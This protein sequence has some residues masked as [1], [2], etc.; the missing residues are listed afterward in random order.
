VAF[1][2]ALLARGAAAQGDAGPPSVTAQAPAAALEAPVLQA[3][4]EAVYPAQA[5]VERREANVGL[6]L[7]LDETGKV[8]SARVTSPAGHGFDEAALA[9]ARQ[10]RFQPA[11]LAGVP[12]RSSVQFTYEFQLPAP[13]ASPGETPAASVAAP[14]APRAERGQSTLVL[15]AR[16]ISAA[17]AF[18]V[19]SRDF[20]LRPIGS[21]QDILRVTPGLV[22]VQHS[23]GGKANQYFMRG[24]DADHGTDLAL[25]IDG[26]PI[27]MPSHAHGQGFSDTHFIIPELV[28]RVEIT[29]GPYFVSQGDFATAGAVNLVTR[30]SSEQSSIGF[31]LFGSPG[32]GGFGYRGLAIA[33]P[34]LEGAR[35]TFAA[36]IGRSAGPFDNPENWDRYKLFN[37]LSLSLTDSSTLSLGHMSY[38]SNWRGSGQIPD[39]AVQQGLI[40]RFGSIDPD[41][42]GNS[43]RHQW[44]AQYRARPSEQSDFKLLAY[45]GTYGFDMFSNFT[46]FLNDPAL[47]DEIEQVDRRTFVGGR[48]SYRVLHELGAVR[49]D[50]TLGADVRSDDIDAELWNTAQRIRRSAVRNSQ[51][52]ETFLG[53]YLNEEITPAR[54]F[55]ANLGLRADLLSFAVADRLTEVQGPGG[56]AP[57]GGVGADHQL[58]PK[59]SLIFTPVASEQLELDLYANYGHGF[60]SNDVR[61]VFATPAVTPLTRAIGEELGARARLFG[62]WDLALAL[63]RLDLDNETVWIGD[64]GT[65]EVGDATRRQGVELETR[66]EITPWLAADLDLTFTEANL[67]EDAES[68]SGLALSP[69]QTW[70]GGVSAR[71]ALGPG[72]GRAGVRFYGIG[73][74]PASDDGVL[75]ASGFTQ[76]DVHVG[77][78]QRWFDVALDIENLFNASFRA[79]QFATVSRLP[80]EPLPGSAA[81]SGFSCGRSGRLAAA[82]DGGAPNGVFYGCE[83]V[84]Y[85]PAYPFTAR[86]LATLFLD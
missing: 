58:S 25:S 29:K 55:R 31:G 43:S 47:G 37:K 50:T 11:R 79:A 68:A 17:S 59:A 83:E 40:T 74:R 42:G 3:H 38:A 75:V 71:H 13:P 27:N 66:Y 44:F 85:T 23:G 33:S 65:T 36:E 72:T 18:S 84:N 54:W 24:F 7:E 4:V 61:G 9:A 56:E 67:R 14:P 77:Y 60:H 49:L 35:A 86:I 16:P 22:L 5:L 82:P 19:R 39:R 62:R 53:A 81:P 45:V 41:E 6:E 2:L 46:L 20:Q 78:R 8:S 69:K 21:V 80:N 10:L 76:F 15:A 28:E 32:Q 12:I 57:I 48:T 73:D 70:A 30:D 1:G 26:I 51:I 52:Q 64:A 34:K 63:W